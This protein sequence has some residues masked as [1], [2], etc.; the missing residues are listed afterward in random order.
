MSYL[1]EE[2][3]IPPFDTESYEQ[4][5]VPPE[6][7]VS[8]EDCEYYIANAILSS[9]PTKAKVAVYFVDEDHHTK[10]KHNQLTFVIKKIQPIMSDLCVLYVQHICIY[11]DYFR[12]IEDGGTE[13]KIGS[14][15][16]DSQIHQIV[17]AYRDFVHRKFNQFC[18]KFVDQFDPMRPNAMARVYE[19]YL[20]EY[21]D[22]RTEEWRR[23]MTHICDFE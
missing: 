15:N 10:I 6:C 17:D 14:M 1:R 23:S 5:L 22:V 20:R 18:H 8:S 19:H 9:W 2:T 16:F 4:S 21:P 12:W 13:I 7:Y 11:I 3:L